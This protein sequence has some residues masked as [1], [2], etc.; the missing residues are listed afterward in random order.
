MT[1][2]LHNGEGDKMARAIRFW[3]DYCATAPDEASSL[4]ATGIVPPSVHHFPENI[5]GKP[6]VLI[7]A[8]YS[9]A[10][11]KG[12][13][14]LQPL[15][16]IDVPLIDFSGVMPYVEAQRMFDDDYPDGMRY[17]WKSLNLLRLDDEVIARIVEHARKQPSVF[18]TIDLWH[19]GG[20]AT[21]EPSGGSAFNGRHV[22][23]LVSPEANWEHA[24]D[25][26]AN[27]A[28]LRTLIAD[29]EQYSDGGRYL[30]FAGFQEEGDAMMAAAF[31]PHHARLLALK[32][33]Y[34]PGNLFCLNQ[35]I[36]PRSFTD[37]GEMEAA[38][39]R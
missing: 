25:D 1:F 14:E 9:G 24:A 20:A 30:N 32:N 8:L 33:Q 10:P 6:F 3:R 7:G 22:P 36:A 18:S 26:R 31:G 19:I 21:R 2:V 12:R 37:A 27:I 28:W 29:M 38:A 15:S 34:D 39:G 4:L 11:S 23:F 5:W 16:D 35:N 13:H 17:Y